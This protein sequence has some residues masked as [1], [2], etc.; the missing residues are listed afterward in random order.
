[1]ENAEAQRGG[2]ATKERP[3]ITQ[4]TRMDYPIRVIRVIRGPKIYAGCGNF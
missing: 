1:M 4:I 3:Q 2:A